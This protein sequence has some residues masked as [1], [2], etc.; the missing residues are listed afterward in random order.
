[1]AKELTKNTLPIADYHVWTS[2]NM[3][4]G[5]ILDVYGSLGGRVAD[6]VTLESDGGNSVVKFNVA[7]RVHAQHGGHSTV[8]GQLHNSWSEVGALRPAPYL[9]KEIEVT[10]K[11]EILIENN[12]AQSW[13]VD[14]L[15]VRDIKVVTDSGLRITVT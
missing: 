6:T 11:D 5:D 14:E 13:T 3:S 9:V 15:G 1:M 2:S 12:T 7:T 10:S 8:S 4:E